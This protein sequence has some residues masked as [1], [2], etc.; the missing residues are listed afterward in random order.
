[1]YKGYLISIKKKHIVVLISFSIVLIIGIAYGLSIMEVN[2]LLISIIL[3]IMIMIL[4]IFVHL[5]YTKKE[6]KIK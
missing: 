1:M 6:E 3:S 5:N 2:H 4:V